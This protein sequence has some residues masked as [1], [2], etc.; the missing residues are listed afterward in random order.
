[1]EFKYTALMFLLLGL[2]IYLIGKVDK[3][4]SNRKLNK[5]K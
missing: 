2:F 3:F 1:M 5:K 4:F